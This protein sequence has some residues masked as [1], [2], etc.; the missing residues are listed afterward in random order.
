MDERKRTLLIKL[1]SDLEKIAERLIA[2]FNIRHSKEQAHLSE[3]IFRW[4][5]FS[6]R[7]VTPWPRQVFL[8]QRFPVS[9]PTQYGRRLSAIIRM[10][11]RGNDINSLQGKGLTKYQ[12]VSSNQ[13]AK[14]TDLLLADWGIHHFHIAKPVKGFRGVYSERSD[15]LLYAVVL[16]NAVLLV[17]VRKHDETGAF[18][19]RE[20][21]ETLIRSFPTYAER[22][23]MHGILAGV[24][25]A[26]ED[27][28]QLRRGGVNAPII[29]DDAVYISPGMGLT[30]AGTPVSINMAL[31]KVHQAIGC[32]ADFVLEESGQVQ[33]FVKEN[34]IDSPEYTLDISPRGLGLFES[35]S[36]I[37]WVFSEVG[38][39]Q[40]TPLGYLR[41]VFS[42][43]WVMAGLNEKSRPG[44]KPS[45]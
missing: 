6:L 1:D 16:S 27:V 37:S 15:W 41:E 2:H 9:I 44:L 39:P 26:D 21:I 23:R 12:D 45:C 42:P 11:Q 19:R 30:T 24:P 38:A 17:D 14:R 29:V 40:G 3:S 34:G 32:L 5:D 33:R 7:Y 22:F 36:N 43:V 8:S 25:L 18:E 20:L 31:S 13:R 35:K 10:L 4:L 28:R